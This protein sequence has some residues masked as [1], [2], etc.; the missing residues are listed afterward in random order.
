MVWIQGLWDDAG[1]GWRGANET[2]RDMLG[3]VD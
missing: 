3:P 2:A 1:P